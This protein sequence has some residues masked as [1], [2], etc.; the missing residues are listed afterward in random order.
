MRI[1]RLW[2]IFIV[3]A[4]GVQAHAQ[5][6]RLRDGNWW[7]SITAPSKDAYMVG[8]FDGIILGGQ[9]SWW[10]LVGKDGT[11]DAREADRTKDSFDTYY[12]MLKGTTNDQFR[13]GLDTF[14]SDYRNRRIPIVHGF[15]IVLNT[16]AGKPENEL[17]VMIE[18]F[19]KSAGQ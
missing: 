8:F 16:I 7:R 5:D 14:C 4:C 11:L 10:H 3:I 15:W 17:N 12:K 18:N 13:D 1:H 2:A 19:R 9:F 6:E